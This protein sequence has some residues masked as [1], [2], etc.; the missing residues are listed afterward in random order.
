MS[1]G[2]NNSP[3]FSSN[4]LTQKSE[5]NQRPRGIGRTCSRSSCRRIATVTLTYVYADS[6]AVLGPLAT[7][8]EPHA[9][10]LCV[11]HSDR[12]TVPIGWSVFQHEKN[13]ALM[14]PSEDDLLTIANAVREVGRRS[15]EEEEI[16]NKETILAPEVG[17][18]GHLRAIP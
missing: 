15:S 12:L 10:D 13:G 11:A 9:Y 3:D 16:K 2:R 4:R 5:E 8:A 1:N 6:V 18:R 14:G 17:R 7:F